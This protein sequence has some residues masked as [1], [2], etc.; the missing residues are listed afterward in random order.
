M[1]RNRWLESLDVQHKNE[2]L[3]DLELYLKALDRFCNVR[4]HAIIETENLF[5]RDFSAEI[6]ILHDVLSKVIHYVHVLLPEKQS[7]AFHFQTFVE[8]RLLSDRTRME[9]MERSLRQSSPEE[10]LY[11]LENAM[12]SMRE[13]VAGITGLSRVS[14][15]LFNHLGQMISREIAWNTYFNPFQLGDFS[16]V[17]DRI[18]NA[19]IQKVVKQNVPTPLKREISIIFLL[20]FRL[21]R[22]LTYIQEDTPEIME[23]KNNL[24]LFALLRSEMLTLVDYLEREL[25]RLIKEKA[26]SDG[27]LKDAGALLDGLA[28]QVEMELK[29]TYHL[30]LKDAATL[31]ELNRLSTGIARA[32]GV[33][34]EILRQTAVQL[35]QIIDPKVEGRHIFRDYISR[36]ELSLKLRKD[37]WI[38]HK[39]VENLDQTIL[40]N[41]PGE[42]FRQIIEAIKSLRNYIFYFQNVSYQMVRYTDRESFLEFFRRIDT[43]ILEDIYSPAK[44]T[45]LHLDVHAFQLFLETT[46]ANLSM[47]SELKGLP[48][49]TRE[50]E[51][52]LE[53]FLK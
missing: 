24:A 40:K 12:T 22:Y 36:T 27:Q 19:A 2:R 37:I 14:Y 3:F 45:E 35:T 21:L 4:N 48:F 34:I 18:R 51:A 29:K 16:P 25:P 9:W 30:E 11:V 38:F 43:F 1:E 17:N 42:D 7:S 47:R 44:L 28:F 20:V 8:W 52:I 5:A 50:G 32:K 6:R 13:V 26:Q 33:L 53:Q 39:V 10:S 41:M 23:L 15:P 49:G 46:I 31:T